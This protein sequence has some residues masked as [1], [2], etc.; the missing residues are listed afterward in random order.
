M[1]ILFFVLYNDIGFLKVHFPLYPINYVYTNVQ[2]YIRIV[3]SLYCGEIKNM[4]KKKIFGT[5]KGFSLA[6]VLLT[7][8]IIGVLGAMLVPMMNQGTGRHEIL[9]KVNKAHSVIGQGV[10]KIAYA[11]GLPIADLSFIKEDGDVV[12]F[13]K[14]S[15]FVDTIK[16]C[17]G[18]A[19]GCFPTDDITQL[20][21]LST[22]FLLPYSLITKDGISYGWQNKISCGDKGLSVDDV[23][24][25]YGSFVVDINGH[26][27]PNRYGYDI[28]FFAIVDKKGVVPAGKGN[29][30][31]DCRRDR[32]GITC[33][34]KVIDDQGV[35]YH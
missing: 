24:N 1:F 23:R 12:F 11:E 20:D 31:Y 25:C 14:F 34:S 3:I 26:K 2:I 10:M 7:L 19:D 6:E 22:S 17:N 8:V 28:F 21:G 29:K 18:T 5:K 35:N 27:P 16:L 30:S 4:L 32:A 9:V 13:E 15:K 33:A